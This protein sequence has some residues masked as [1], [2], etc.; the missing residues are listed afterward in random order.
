MGKGIFLPLPLVMPQV[1]QCG[2]SALHQVNHRGK[3]EQLHV[4]GSYPERRIGYSAPLPILPHTGI[5][6]PLP[7]P[8]TFCFCSALPSGRRVFTSTSSQYTVLAG[9][10]RFFCW[11]WCLSTNSCKCAL[12][13]TCHALGRRSYHYACIATE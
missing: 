4:E 5:D 11:C 2:Y 6:L 8:E 10:H 1:A 3:S 12:W 9:W 13:Y 7:L